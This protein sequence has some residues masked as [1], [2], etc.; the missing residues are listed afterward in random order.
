MA[1]YLG[2]GVVSRGSVDSGPSS[3]VALEVSGIAGS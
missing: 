1:L 3:V 2:R